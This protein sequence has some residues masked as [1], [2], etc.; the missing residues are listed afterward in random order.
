MNEKLSRK[1]AAQVRKLNAEIVRLR[2]AI[3][4]IEEPYAATLAA[5]LVGQCFR[6]QN[7]Y[8]C[9]EKPSDYWWLYTKVRCVDG[10]GVRCITFQIDKDGRASLERDDFRMPQSLD[11]YDSITPAEFNRQHTKFVQYVVSANRDA[12]P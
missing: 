6:I 7:N 8:S 12:K 4:D 11:G 5:N 3:H 10:A 9:P 1:D 2:N